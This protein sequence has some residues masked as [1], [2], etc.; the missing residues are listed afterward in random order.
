MSEQSAPLNKKLIQ[1]IN[2]KLAALGCPVVDL[3]DDT[4]LSEMHA[5][6]A[7]QREIN[8]L[9]ADYLCAA[10]NRIQTFLYDYLQ[11]APLAKLPAGTFVLDRPGLARV[12]SLP[13]TRD[14]FTS[15]IVNSFRVRQGVLHNPRSDRR[16]TEGIFHVVEGGFPI[17]DDKIS[18]PKRV[19][20]RLLQLALD[21]PPELLRLPFTA[22]QA[23]QAECF[24]SL[25][26]RPIVCPEVPGFTSEKSMEIRF[27]AP[28]SLVSNLDFVES[29]FGNAGDPFL[30]ENDSALDPEHWTGHT[31]CVILAP[32]LTKVGKKE[33]G[34]PHWNNATDRQRRDRMCWKDDCEPYN[35]GVAFKITCRDETG[36]IV[37]VIADNYYGYCKKEVKTQISFSANLAGLCEEEHAGG[38]LVF[39][40]YDLGEE[41]IPELHT[42][43]SDHRLDDMVSRYAELMEMRAEGYAI[44]RRF[45]DIF[46]VPED[47]RFDLHNQAVTWLRNGA[48]I[49][50]KL[51]PGQTYVRPSGYKI[52]MHKPGAGRAW[53][54][55]GTVSEGMLCHKPSTVSAG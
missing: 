46:Y 55:V 37:T 14:S 3:G 19:A 42:R 52:H 6:L 30:P 50:L 48:E 20:G 32:H 1:Y 7:H 29:I 9:L 43:Q 41:F 44:D 18:V 16:T 54:L 31:G 49:R 2:L 12:L 23:K 25:L 51:L 15:E 27:I 45:A 39:P 8:R 38:A 17:P 24:V 34:L 13:P 11:D 40:S 26:L 21:P 28:G 4:E 53:R 5:L 35:N 47:A 10:D 33:L 22:A 36:V